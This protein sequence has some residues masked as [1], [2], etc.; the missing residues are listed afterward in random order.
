LPAL[1]AGASAPAEIIVDIDRLRDAADDDPAQMQKL[2]E[3][4]LSEAAPMMEALERA[5][6]S[7]SSAEV[8]RLAHKMVGSSLSCGV[9]ALA[10]SLRELEKLGRSENLGEAPALF[11]HVR[12]KF[13][14]VR[15]IFAQFAGTL[16]STTPSV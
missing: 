6:Q 2:I 12:Q 7:N 4:Y 1:P 13:P 9:E 5:I 3:L 11:E 16:V 10:E 15:K 14:Q 8:A